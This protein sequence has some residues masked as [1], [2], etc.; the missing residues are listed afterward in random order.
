MVS[1]RFEKRR[2]R[3]MDMMNGFG[4]L[5]MLLPLFLWGGLLALIVWLVVRVFPG[6]PEEGRSTDKAEEALRER[7]AR[8]EMDE[9]EYQRSL[10]TLREEPSEYRDDNYARL[11]H[12]RRS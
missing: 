12:E 6:S 5:W 11:D 1:D 4:V 3:M 9:E 7:F 10:R 8:G 2:D